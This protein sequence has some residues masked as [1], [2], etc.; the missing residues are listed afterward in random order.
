MLISKKEGLETEAEHI[1]LYH[2]EN[3]NL[4]VLI[5]WITKQG[6]TDFNRNR[7]DLG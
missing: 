2:K 3:E 4:S 1:K 7:I 5:L 6:N